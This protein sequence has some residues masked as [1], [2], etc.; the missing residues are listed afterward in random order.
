[1]LEVNDF[2]GDQAESNDEILR[3]DPLNEE[4]S[5]DEQDY[6]QEDGSDDV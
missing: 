4:N 5:L 6:L 2:E 3:K 1:M